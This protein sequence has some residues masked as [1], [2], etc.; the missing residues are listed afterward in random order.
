MKDKILQLIKQK[1]MF[2]TAL[3]IADKYDLKNDVITEL[4]SELNTEITLEKLKD[5]IDCEICNTTNY[6]HLHINIYN[7]GLIYRN[8][9]TLD[10]Y[11]N[12]KLRY[13]SLIHNSLVRINVCH[14]IL[15]EMLYCNYNLLTEI[16][17]SKNINLQ[18]LNIKDNLITGTLDL[19]NNY[20]LKELNTQGNISLDN[21]ILN[22]K[23]KNKIQLLIDEHTKITY[24]YV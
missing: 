20:K 23:V 18:I 10:F 16:D 17:L 5:I 3:L 22:N 9:I 14:N 6:L 2:D 11:N 1:G 4:K 15:L 19:S 13:I 8:V 7:F 21:I 24:K 12:K